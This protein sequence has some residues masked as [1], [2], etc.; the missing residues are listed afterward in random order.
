MDRSY[1]CRTVMWFHYR[2][3]PPLQAQRRVAGVNDG[4]FRC[5]AWRSV[6]ENAGQSLHKG[7]RV[8][9]VGKLIQR[10]FEVEG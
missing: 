5:T 6:P 8:L 1:A 3:Q 2:G 10:T 7:D 4:F 9:V